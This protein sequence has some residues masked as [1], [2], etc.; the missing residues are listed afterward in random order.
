M[1]TKPDERRRIFAS[2]TNSPSRGREGEAPA[3]PI[4]SQARQEPRPPGG[5]RTS[6]L[7]RRFPQPSA[8]ER[9]PTCYY[10]ET[11]RSAKKTVTPATTEAV[12][13]RASFF[14]HFVSPI[15]TIVCH[16]PEDAKGSWH[17]SC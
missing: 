12:S 6:H 2:W 17:K 10:S 16:D 11:L 4:H 15:P 14:C 5:K 13:F 9:L 3:E 7:V 1:K 8:S